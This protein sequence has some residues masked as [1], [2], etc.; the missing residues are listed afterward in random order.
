MSPVRLLDSVRQAVRLRHYSYRTEKAY[1]D[2]IR[3]YVLFHG[4]RHPRDMG[5]HEVTEFL[6]HLAS[7]R[8]VA[9]ATQ[10]Q[11]LAALLFLYKH[12]LKVD[13]PWLENVIRA[14]RPKRLPTVLREEEAK[15]VIANVS[16]P[17]SLVAGLLYG[18]G[19][20]LLEALRLRIKDVDFYHRRIMIR[21]GKGFKDR[22][23]V[24]PDSMLEPLKH[25]LVQVRLLHEQA[26]RLGYGGVELPHALSRKCPRASTAWGWQYVFPATRPSV[27]PR[28][29][30]SRRHHI[31]ED[32][33]QRRVREAAR[34]AGIEAPV[35][36][37][38][39]RHSFAT[40]LLEDGY[41][42]RTVQELLGHKDVSTTQIYTHVMA[43]GTSS[44]RSPLDGPRVPAQRL[45][46]AR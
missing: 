40:H 45:T 30:V 10:A 29:G 20:R 11:A 6:S 43:P 23:T 26:M 46:R 21:D 5:G 24:L 3:R 2:W 31:M 8:Q 16:A 25:H 9:A 14:R 42:I 13:L 19:L 39:F 7:S 15:R 32:T 37:H 44:V 17:Y 12:V 27:D 28:S 4:K 18:S 41:D 1:V 36:P 34:K 33:I 35:S 38:T 22:V